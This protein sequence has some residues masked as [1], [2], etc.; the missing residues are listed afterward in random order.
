MNKKGIILVLCVGFL[1]TGCGEDAVL[2]Q[3]KA[4]KKP[5]V[6]SVYEVTWDEEKEPVPIVTR[7]ESGEFL[8][9]LQ[10]MLIEMDVYGDN[11]FERDEKTKEL[12]VPDW[13]DW[14]SVQERAFSL[15]SEDAYS[16]DEM[17]EE[18]SKF[19][20]ISGYYMFDDIIYTGKIEEVL[21]KLERLGVAN[22]V[23]P[24]QTF[25]AEYEEKRKQETEYLSLVRQGVEIIIIA[26]ADEYGLQIQIPKA[27][28]R[29]PGKY[30]EF[31]RTRVK[32]GF[33]VGAINAGG[34]M[35]RLNFISSWNECDNPYNKCIDF[36]YKD[37]KPLELEIKMEKNPNSRVDTASTPL[38]TQNEK[39]TMTNLVAE[40]CGDE[41][42]AAAFVSDFVVGKEKEGTVG[43]CRWTLEKKY[44]YEYLVLEE[45]SE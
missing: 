36:Y 20:N 31:F 17:D 43:K 45:E 10:D 23:A 30:E 38:F 25:A 24:F 13:R 3:A 27:L 29:V 33:Y 11:I 41:T 9:R 19:G 8:N 44:G 18:D 5:F 16:S 1:L 22:L 28:I 7:K 40:I 32:D 14:N 6:D 4:E 39:E 15:S 37:G 26:G 12:L 34:Y 21:N 35:D 42:S 2:K